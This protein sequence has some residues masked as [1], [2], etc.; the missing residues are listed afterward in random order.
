MGMYSPGK[1]HT[2][3]YLDPSK[4]TKVYGVE[5]NTVMHSALRREVEH[6]KLGDTY[7]IV[8]A[9]LWVPASISILQYGRLNTLL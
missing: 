9:Y 1:G 8:C 6:C 5:P 7:T 2:L 4:I 3:Q